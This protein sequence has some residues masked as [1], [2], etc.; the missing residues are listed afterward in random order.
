M[1][2]Y[3]PHPKQPRTSL[4]RREFLR[5]AA[6]A[7][8]VL[9]GVSAIL[10]ACG[11]GAQTSVSESPTGATSASNKY[12]TGGVGGAPYPLARQNAPVTWKIQPGNEPIASGLAPE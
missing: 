1:T 8:I 11:A 6:A 10:A 7:G 12:G 9:P 5:R 3:S 4:S 2:W